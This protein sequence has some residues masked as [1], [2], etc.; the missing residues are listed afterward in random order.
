MECSIRNEEVGVRYLLLRRIS[1]HS[2]YAET[3]KKLIES[4]SRSMGIFLI[5]IFCPEEVFTYITE[6][7]LPL[8]HDSI[9]EYHLCISWWIISR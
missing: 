6:K 5:I 1:L 4:L 3:L 7:C 8:H 2:H 9:R